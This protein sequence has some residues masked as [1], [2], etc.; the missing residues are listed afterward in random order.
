MTASKE[1]KKKRMNDAGITVICGPMFAG[2]T[3]MVISE[4]DAAL[5][6]GE[7]VIVVKPLR[8][9]RYAAG[10]TS[11][12]SHDGVARNAVLIESLTEWWRRRRMD[13]QHQTNRVFVDEGQFFTEQDMLTFLKAV[14]QHTDVSVV[15]AGLDLDHARRPFESM[16]VA[17]EQADSITRLR[18]KC[19]KCGSLDAVFTSRIVNTQDR[20]YVGGAES[21][22]ARCE[23]C[24]Q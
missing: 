6:G 1:K 22:E 21:Y 11:I 16:T 4:I 18:S 5:T 23:T 20:F 7:T 3:T 12:V 2:K 19:S 17:I 10:S 24:Y 13:Q 8:D 9:Q 15:I 14:R